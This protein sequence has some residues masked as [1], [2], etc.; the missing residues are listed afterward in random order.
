[1]AD[2]KGIEEAGDTENS[3][4]QQ[5]MQMQIEDA[6]YKLYKGYITELREIDRVQIIS[7]LNNYLTYH[8]FTRDSKLELLDMRQQV[9]T[10]AFIFNDQYSSCKFQGIM[11][12]SRAAGILSAGEPQVQ[13]LQKRDLMIWVNAHS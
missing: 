5:F 2:Y 9:K 3:S 10:A 4:I 12:D 1:L 13:A 11:L 8:L 7:V 6:L